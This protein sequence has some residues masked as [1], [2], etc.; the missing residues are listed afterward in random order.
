MEQ[1]NVT[2]LIFDFLLPLVFITC[3]LLGCKGRGN[4]KVFLMDDYKTTVFTQ[5]LTALHLG[6][7]LVEIGPGGR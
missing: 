7:Y 3:P 6:F 2:I 5:H 4:K 1:P